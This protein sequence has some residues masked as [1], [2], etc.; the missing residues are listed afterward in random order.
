MIKEE[1]WN[2]GIVIII[3]ILILVFTQINNIRSIFNFA[4]EDKQNG[5]YYYIY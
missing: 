1:R 5:Q 3:I 4:S 2:L